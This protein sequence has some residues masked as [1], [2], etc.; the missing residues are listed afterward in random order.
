MFNRTVR[1]KRESKHLSFSRKGRKGEKGG[2]SPMSIRRPLRRRE[3]DGVCLFWS[4]GRGGE[5]RG[6]T[7]TYRAKKRTK[8]KGVGGRILPFSGR[9]R[10]GK[11]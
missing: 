5:R 11:E 2:Q 6:A 7:L 10:R 1:K 8:E 9:D 4:V 3:K